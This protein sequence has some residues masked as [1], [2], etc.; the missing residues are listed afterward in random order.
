M[1]EDIWMN[2]QTIEK[3]KESQKCRNGTTVFTRMSKMF[4]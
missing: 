2:A 4:Y 1:N 3:T